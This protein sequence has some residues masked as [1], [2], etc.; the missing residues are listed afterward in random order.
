VASEP[1]SAAIATSFV[2]LLNRDSGAFFWLFREL[3]NPLV[4]NASDALEEL[5]A[6]TAEMFPRAFRPKVFD[7]RLD[8][9]PRHGTEKAA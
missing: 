2:N 7:H 9:W 8:L 5:Y 6:R 3:L 1:K 4:E